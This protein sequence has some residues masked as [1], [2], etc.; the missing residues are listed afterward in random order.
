MTLKTNYIAP[1]I[2]VTFTLGIGG[3]MAFNLWKTESSKLPATYTSG[4]FAGLAN[5][6]DIR[7]SY[8]FA[9]VNKS[10]GIAVT[11]LAKAFGVESVENPETFKCKE[12]EDLYGDIQGGEIGTD[13]VRWFVALYKDLPFTPEADT[14]LPAPAMGLLRE[15][16]TETQSNELRERVVPIS[17]IKPTTDAST[18]ERDAEQRTVLGMTTFQ[19]LLDWGVTEEEFETITGLPVGKSNMA[20]R[21]Y[22]SEQGTELSSFKERLQK[23]VESK[24][25]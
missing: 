13:S 21:D 4:E 19:Q 16:L 3:T 12:L 10:F 20:L 23:L 8:S 25:Q 5:P 7:G 17:G 1:I 2:L 15:K 11:D 22:F 24:Q 18:D 6:A 14:L 9:D